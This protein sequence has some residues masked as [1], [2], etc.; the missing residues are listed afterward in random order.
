MI[1]RV[2]QS[3]DE[4]ANISLFRWMMTNGLSN[5]LLKVLDTC[6]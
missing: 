3:E 4:L 6:W 5:Q 2:I 1:Q